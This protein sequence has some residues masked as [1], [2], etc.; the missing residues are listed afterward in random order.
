MEHLSCAH[1]GSAPGRKARRLSYFSAAPRRSDAATQPE[2]ALRPTWLF[3]LSKID[4]S[5][6]ARAQGERFV[7]HVADR[8]R[9]TVRLNRH[10][11]LIGPEDLVSAVRARLGDAPGITLH[12]NLPYDQ[13]M[14]SLMAAEYS[15]FWNYFSFSILHRVLDNR[16]AFF[17]HAGHMA[18]TLPALGNEGVRVIY[19]GWRPPLLPVD[20]AFDEQDLARRAAEVVREFGRIGEGVR[21]CPSPVEVLR[22]AT[23]MAPD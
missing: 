1:H 9:D 6:Q 11:M 16:P 21:R 10:A 23:G 12:S 17:F 15:F 2:A 7:D 8:L 18:H 20:S 22:R 3:V 4:S 14:R 19:D 13:Y 5:L